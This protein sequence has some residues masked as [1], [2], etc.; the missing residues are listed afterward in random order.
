VTSRTDAAPE[1]YYHSPE[2]GHT[3]GYLLPSVARALSGVAAGMVLEAGCGNGGTAAW[4]RS[5]GWSVTAIHTSESGVGIARNQYPGIRFEVMSVYED[6]GG[7]FGA[8][9]AVVSL[10]VIE[11]LYDPRAFAKNVFAALKPGGVLV[12]STPYHGYLKNLALALTGAM[13]AHFTALWPNGHIKFWSMRT[14]GQLLR[15]AGFE[16][17]EFDR[18][19]RIPPLAKSMVVRARKPGAGA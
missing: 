1:Y 14:L 9:D 4:L 2:A 12:L 13:D 18:V 17:I 5:R 19:G 8:F 15:E 10:E 3:S 6:L 7:T 11:H 16:N